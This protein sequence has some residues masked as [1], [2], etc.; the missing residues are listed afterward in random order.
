[1]KRNDSITIALS[2]Y[3]PPYQFINN[4]NRIEGIFIDYI[5]LIEHKI[6]YKF[7]R[8][9]YPEWS[10]LIHDAKKKKTDII[11]EIEQT[12]TRNSYLNFYSHFFESNHVIVT[13]KHT[14]SVKKIT[15]LLNKKITVPKDYAISENLKQKYPQLIFIE[16]KDDLTCLKK[17]N[18][19]TYDSY[20]GPLSVV[21][22]LIKNNNLNN[23]KT[24][25]ETNI[26]YIP[27]IAVDKENKLLNDI[28]KKAIQDI[29]DTEKKNIIE[30]WLYTKRRP[31]YKNAN[32]LIPFI[33]FIILGF[34]LIL[35]INFY[36]SYIVKQKTKAVRIAKENSEKDNQLKTAFINNISH[37]IRTPM[38][39]IIGFSQF[40]KDFTTTN[41]EKTLYTEI[42]A[43]SSQQ[44]ID[45]MDNILEISKLQAKLVKLNP[46]ET[47]LYAVFN[48]IH[49][50][51]NTKA[52]KKDI[53]LLLSN[54][55][56]EHHRY[57]LID[58][59]KLIK[60]SK[61]LIENAIKFT[62]RGAVLI[63]CTVKNDALIVMVRDSGIGIAPKDKEII[64]QSFSQS[65][66]KISKRYGGLGLGLTIAKENINLMGGELSFTSIPNK[67]STFRF[68]LPHSTIAS[69]NNYNKSLIPQKSNTK[70]HTLLIA[71]DGDVNFLIIKTILLKIENYDFIIHRA[72]NGK[73][74]VIFCKENTAIDLVFMDIKMPEMNGYDASKL[75]KKLY[76]KLPIVA[77]TAYTT[78]ED[79]KTAFDAGCDDFISKPID[80]IT[81]KKIILKY[82]PIISEIN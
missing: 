8:K 37:E 9:Y 64:F 58:K 1:M 78:K 39:G 73:E 2:P 46:E 65:E 28:I 4:D 18:S 55:I 76:P 16:D 12:S 26:K 70:Q 45:S 40:L 27:K 74:A 3:Y 23:L 29:S 82:L 34:F 7:K 41:Y 10:K 21:N 57:A 35:G 61:G 13:R 42:V 62:K 81:L 52:K 77:Q 59:E 71:E 56:K 50:M 31:F 30:N 24:V 69:T 20:I 17:L 47:D 75:I 54:T 15:D 68:K 80:P 48:T 33:L 25:S 44:L 5:E 53:T 11:I 49:R 43:N 60:I 72:K 67:G 14:P 66:N 19:G 51:F 32:F 63:S 38:N 22:Y 6:D 36:L 79:I